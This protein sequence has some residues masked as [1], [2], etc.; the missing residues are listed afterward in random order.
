MAYAGSQ[1]ETRK[2]MEKALQL[3]ENSLSELAKLS[4]QVKNISENELNIANSVW[5]S[6][7]VE[8]QK[9]FQ[10]KVS[11]LDALVQQCDFKTQGGEAVKQINKFVADATKNMIP[12]IM[13]NVAAD[14]IWI[15]V[16]FLVDLTR[17]K[18]FFD[19]RIVGQ[20]S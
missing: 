5:V 1:G 20:C 11:K 7:S 6:K 15:L 13:D 18:S 3:S 16:R 4:Q 8:L 9:D 14:T 12:S 17:S 10:S 2:E 19:F